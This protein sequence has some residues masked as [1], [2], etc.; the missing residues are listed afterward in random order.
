[1]EPRERSG[2]VTADACATLLNAAIWLAGTILV[3]A[4]IWFLGP[5]V[6]GLDG[7][8]VRLVLCGVALLAWAAVVTW[9]H[10]R[11]T[12]RESALEQGLLG[13]SDDLAE[14]AAGLR[15]RF[16]DALK[17]L[18][19]A[20]LLHSQPWYVIIGPPGAGEDDGAV[21]RR[22]VVSAGRGGGR[23]ASGGGGRHAKLR[24]VV[25]RPGGA[26]RHRRALHHPG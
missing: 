11:R 22:A 23:R 5:L 7:A 2:D 4:L 20:R 15:A 21:E 17:T 18:K 19:G 8:A 12:R 14:E 3:I 10:I 1:M 16:A 24:L 26:D 13:S 9:S 25:H 6:P